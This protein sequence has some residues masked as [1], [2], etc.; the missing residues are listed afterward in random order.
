MNKKDHKELKEVKIAD[1][2]I[3]LNLVKTFHFQK[4]TFHNIIMASGIAQNLYNYRYS[5]V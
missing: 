4:E 2:D 5:K 1:Y 3:V